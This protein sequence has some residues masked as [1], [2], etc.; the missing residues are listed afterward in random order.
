M[1]IPCARHTAAA[2]S[3][4]PLARSVV[5]VTVAVRVVDSSAELGFT[6]TLSTTDSLFSMST[7]SSRLLPS[8]SPSQA[9]A[10]QVTLSP[11]MKPDARVLAVPSVSVR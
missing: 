4:R 8:S 10:V 7:V 6:V 9:V 2:A 3:S 1:E 11:L 5:A